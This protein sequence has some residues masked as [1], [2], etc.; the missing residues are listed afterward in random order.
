IAENGR[1]GYVIVRGKDAGRS[2]V[3]AAAELAKYI[4]QS[5]GAQLAVVTD[6]LPETVREILVGKTNR[7]E[8]GLVNRK[9]LGTDG[10]LIKAVNKKLIIAGG[11]VR[12]TL[13]GV[14]DFL[15]DF[16]GCRFFTATLETVPQIRKLAV[17]K[18][19]DVS[20]KPL[21]NFRDTLWKSTFT[22]EIRGKFRLN[23]ELMPGF[24]GSKPLNKN[25]DTIQLFCGTIFQYVG[26]KYF[27][28]HPE[29]FAMNENGERITDQAC[30]SSEGLYNTVLKLIRKSFRENPNLICFYITPN[31]NPNYCQCPK[32]A[33]LDKQEG[34]HCASTL[35][36]VNRIANAVK[37]EF[38]GRTINM[39]AYMYT[40][41]PPKTIIPAENVVIQIAAE[42]SYYMKPYKESSPRLVSDLTGWAAKKSNLLV[43][44]Y[45]TN[46]AHFNILYP[47]VKVAIE[48]VK[49][50]YENGATGIFLQGNGYD[51]GG[52]FGELRAFIA[53]KILWNPYCDIDKDI[54]EFMQAYY[55][56]GYTNI[57]KFIDFTAGKANADWHGGDA[58]RTITLT[59][60]D[61]KYCDALWDAA[62][63][64]IGSATQLF[65]VGRSRIQL[66]Y[67]KSMARKLEF[68]NLNLFRKISENQ[69]L[70]DD[71][72]A[73]GFEYIHEGRRIKPEKPNLLQSADKW[74]ENEARWF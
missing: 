61:L 63:S 6:E 52:E 53:A 14:Y 20:E 68:S 73:S 11:E 40:R 71:M 19:V 64:D 50:F 48:N 27:D 23:G 49:W 54:R 57:L 25:F 42:D 56:D 47:N 2:E 35:N 31:D 51:I 8:D 46:H 33:A 5:T 15:E 9:S 3:F 4:K 55:G 30:F 12:G 17:N 70:Y 59:N 13:F 32:C 24:D 60:S 74:K 1:S 66:R 67:Y 43:W 10:F 29:Y 37:D 44:D 7:S 72:K 34:S 39:L 26:Q 22:P 21:L 58:L 62:E 36:F 65:N 28:S 38:P 41:T 18:S 45:T 69:K 16:L